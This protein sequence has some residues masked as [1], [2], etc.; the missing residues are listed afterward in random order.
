MIPHPA[1]LFLGTIEHILLR[2][3]QPQAVAIGQRFEGFRH[4]NAACLA[5]GV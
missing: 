3:R 1:Q 4:W 5:S 2:R